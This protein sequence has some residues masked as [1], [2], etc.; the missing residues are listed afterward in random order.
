MRLTPTNLTG[1][2][3]FGYFVAMHGDLL[4]VGAPDATLPGG[5]ASA[6]AVLL[7]KR[8]Q[9]GSNA[10]GEIM[11]WSPSGA[12]ADGADFG[13]SV[14]LSDDTLVVGAP[15]YNGD[16]TTLG[17]EGRVFHFQRDEGGADTWG[18]A[19]SIPGASA[20]TADFEFGWSVAVGDGRLAV[21]A[22]STT[23]GSV[24]TAGRVFLYER[25]AS[26]NNF[27]YTIHIDRAS[28]PE[29]FFGYSVALDGERLLVGAP[30]NATIPHLG[31]AFLFEKRSG[32]WV[33]AD[34]PMS[35]AGSTANLFGRAVAMHGGHGIIGAPGSRYG[36]SSATDQGHAYF[37]RLDYTAPAPNAGLTLRQL[38]EKL[39]FGDEVDNPCNIDTLWGG[40]ADPDGDGL[41]NDQEYAFAGDPVV[42]VNPDA[43]SG[44]IYI[45]IDDSGNWVLE[46]ERRS[47][48][49]A[50]VFTLEASA[51]L[52]TWSDWSSSILSETA[53]PI[54]PKSEW[55]TI[56]LQPAPSNDK[57][58][59]RIKA[60]W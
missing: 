11:R 37:Y 15:K 59:F 55:T 41:S 30:Q 40:T 28:D 5:A 38:W 13:W 2:S 57:L 19:Q 47:N 27:A 60:T 16:T 21:G 48:D 17:R 50:I 20:T 54:T 44:L 18:M 9:G 51:D 4:A 1:S 31:A 3:R 7:F 22:P 6:G 43:D 25:P 14:A 35:S 32:N 42:I 52:Q 56:A 49:P 12:G 8:H 23:V 10:W 45:S 29:R 24:G 36:T 26:T 53:V 34:K 39:Y 46:Y 33:Q 58:F